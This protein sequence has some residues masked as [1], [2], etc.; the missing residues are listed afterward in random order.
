LLRALLA[1]PTS[2]YQMLKLRVL[3]A[4]DLAKDAAH[5]YAGVL[6]LLA[7]VVVGR[8]PLRSWWALGPGLVAT[9]VMETLD[10]RD[11]YADDRVWHWRATL[12]DA[13]NTNLLPALI[14]FLDRRGLLKR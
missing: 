3:G 14:V 11:G 8:I 7:A 4:L 9:V 5:V 2:D 13:V 1:V 12:K 10:L 6:L